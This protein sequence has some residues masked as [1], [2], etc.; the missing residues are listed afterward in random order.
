MKSTFHGELLDGAE[1]M[2]M[3]HDGYLACDNAVLGR[4]GFQTYK[5]SELPKDEKDREGI[6]VGDDDNVSVYRSPEEVF[7]PEFMKTLEGKPFTLLHPEKL[8]DITTVTDH[9][10][11]HTQNIRKGDKPLP[12]GDWPLLGD[13][14]VKDPEAIEAI[15]KHGMRELSLG[16]NFHLKKDGS[17]IKMVKMLG[18]HTAVVEKGRAGAMASIQDSAPVTNSKFTLKEMTMSK[19]DA[20]IRAIGFKEWAKTAEPKDIADYHEEISNKPAVA[21]AMDSAAQD[22]HPAGCRCTAKGCKGYVAPA[23]MDS[24]NRKMILDAVGRMLDG[25]EGEKKAIDEADTAALATLEKMMTEGNKSSL[26]SKAVAADAMDEDDEDEKKKDAMDDDEDDDAMDSDEDE[27]EEKE[28][29]EA[30]DETPEIP[31]YARA[32][33]SVPSATDSAAALDAAYH[34]GIVRGQ[35]KTLAGLKPFIAASKDKAVKGAFDTAH[36]VSIKTSTNKPQRGG[37]AAVG[38]ASRTPNAAAMDSVKSG[39]DRQRKAIDDANAEMRARRGKQ[40]SKK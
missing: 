2:R 23:A 5:G 17:L 6:V 30:T 1:N 3:T 13:I 20:V 29:S 28:E 22:V 24:D 34:A 21:A 33:N 4:T 39:E 36:R 9:E 15:L 38:A 10:R 40:V 27:K 37:Y 26:T 19:L 31:M 18:N 8:L 7:N 32:E 25:A 35:K 11:G 14:L 12:S 16:Y